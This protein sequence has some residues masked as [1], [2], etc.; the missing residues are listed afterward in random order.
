M[1][2]F[3]MQEKHMKYKLKNIIKRVVYY[4][5]LLLLK[6][7]FYLF[8][9]FGITNKDKINWVIG[10]DEI[11]SSI[12]FLGSILA[13][14]TTVCL[15]KNKFYNLKYDYFISNRLWRIFYSPIL[16]GYLS[17]KNTHFWYIWHTGFLLDRNLEF[18]FLKAKHKKIV[19]MFN[20]DDIRSIK[21]TMQY[22]KDNAIDT[23]ANYYESIYI[24]YEYEKEKKLLAQSAD[25]YS[26]LIFNFNIDQISYIKSKQYPWRYMYPKEK[27]IKNNDKFNNISKVKILHA[28]SNP[29]LK[30]TQLVRAAIKKI[31]L[32]GY[33][34]EYV[35]LQNVPNYVVEEHLKN[36]HIV[37]NQFYS[38]VPGLFG[39]ECMAKQCA[40][41]M[42]ADPNIETG[43][44]FD[45]KSDIK[46]AWLI[47]KY[48][49]IYDKLKYLLD[50]PDKIKYYANNGYE[51][52][53]SHYTYEAAG[54]YTNKIL[55]ENGI[56]D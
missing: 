19:C 56:I 47:T 2:I 28:P 45:I 29:I 8:R 7:S 44:I 42:S 34:I 4:F 37:L 38:F 22:A 48:W 40:V 16:L 10:V 13:N 17:A 50:N 15:S 41:L 18:K 49:E 39:I 3:L 20:G 43:L 36:S 31:Q 30:G 5:Q 32:E 27:F 24:S 25:K 26:D 35:E 33:D 12:Y 6:I 55:K 14:S 51:F 1:I 46:D 11:A 21:L 53:Y 23:Y 9:F 54:E 52:A